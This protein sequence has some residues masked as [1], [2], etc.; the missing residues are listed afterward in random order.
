MIFQQEQHDLERKLDVARHLA[1][2]V[3]HRHLI[4]E[5]TTEEMHI[6]M[7]SYKKCSDAYRAH[8]EEIIN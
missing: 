7:D 5:A 4:G 8:Q 1:L 3:T 2:D 6:I